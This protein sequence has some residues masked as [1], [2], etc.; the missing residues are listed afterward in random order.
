MRASF[1]FLVLLVAAIAGGVFWVSLVEEPPGPSSPIAGAPL[2]GSADSQVP[3]G[4]KK[5]LPEGVSLEELRANAPDPVA[6][7]GYQA[8]TFDSLSGFSFEIDEQGAAAEGAEIPAELLKLDGTRSAVSGFMVPLAIEQEGVKDFVL[9]K[10][11]L[12]CC[13]GQTPKMNEW[14][15]VQLAPEESVEPILDKPITVAGTLMVGADVQDGQV[16][17]L[18]RMAADQVVEMDG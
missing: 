5:P 13:Y 4:L 3:Q 2:D 6:P 7:E 17:S 9:V 1:L 14:V 18:Y 16:L 11:Q 12:L 10:N 8:V 15:Y